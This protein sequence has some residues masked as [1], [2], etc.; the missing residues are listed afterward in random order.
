MIGMATKEYIRKL[1]YSQG[2]S[3][4]GIERKTGHSRQ[5]VRKVIREE[6]PTIPKYNSTKAKHRP[7]MGPF[8]ETITTWLKEDADRPRKQRHT[9]IRIYERLVEEFGFRGCD[10]T[11]RHCVRTI[12]QKLGIENQEV[13]I[14]LDFELGSHA[15]CDWGYADI[16][17]QGRQQ[18]V[19]LFLLKLSGSRNTFLTA[20]PSE[21]QE[22]FLEGHQRAFQYLGGVP[23]TIVYDNLKTAVTKVLKGKNRI[24]QETFSAF[25]AHYLFEADFCNVGKANEK[26]QAEGD[27][28]YYRRRLLVPLPEVDSLEELNQLILQGLAKHRETRLVP[29]TDQTIEEVFN[30][31]KEYLQPFSDLYHIVLGFV[32]LPIPPT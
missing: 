26:G 25:K 28:G 16:I 19:S 21:K 11:V 18:T 12:K 10:S 31:E 8:L 2:I 15:Q 17:L 1:Y 6:V 22:A 9:A 23:R 4:K 32:P 30:Q 5:Y 14:P 13:F 29:H 7:V 3:I 27:V 24:E 20:L